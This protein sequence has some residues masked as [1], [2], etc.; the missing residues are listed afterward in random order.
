MTT[1]E[2]MASMRPPELPGGKIEA[3]LEQLNPRLIASMR[4]PELPGGKYH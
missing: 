4:P 3:A 2:A 1:D